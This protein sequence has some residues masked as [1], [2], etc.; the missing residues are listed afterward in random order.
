MRFEV[1]EQYPE[2]CMHACH[3]GYVQPFCGVQARRE[4]HSK[5]AE[6]AD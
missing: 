2:I 3:L 5:A 1:Q 6:E 4:G